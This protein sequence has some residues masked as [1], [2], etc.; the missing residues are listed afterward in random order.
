M[1]PIILIRSFLTQ[2][3]CIKIT[4]RN[5]LTQVGYIVYFLK[6]FSILIIFL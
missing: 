3:T 2:Y 1:H 5:T 6:Y 4:T